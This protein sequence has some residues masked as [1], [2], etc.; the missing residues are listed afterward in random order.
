MGRLRRILSY[1]SLSLKFDVKTLFAYPEAFWMAAFTQPLWA[2]VQMIF[3]E[4][5]YGQTSNFLG[6]SKYDSYM[7]YG[8]YKAIQS[9][10]VMIFYL[11]LQDLTEEIRGTSQWS[12]DMMLL[13]PIDSQLFATSGK[14]WLPELTNILV[15]AGMVMYGLVNEPRM[16]NGLQILAYFYVLFLALIVVYVLYF[17]LQ[18]LLFWFD[19]LQVGEAFWI[20]MQGFGKYPRELYHGGLGV[21]VNIAIPV[22]LMGSVPVEYLL[23]RI[24]YT[25]LAMYTVVVAALFLLSR[26][27]WFFSLKRYSSF[28]S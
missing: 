25:M 6:Y 2:I 20:R 15:G 8:T 28:S 19:Y 26:W 3:I 22:T 14:Y 17:V 24:P 21:L 4:T 10:A 5:L 18:T 27:F 13:K 12:L 7:L 16:I 1:Y 9:L 11:R 23:G